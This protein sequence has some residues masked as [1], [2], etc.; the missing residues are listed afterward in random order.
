MV[1][2]LVK[3]STLTQ[4]KSKIGLYLFIAFLALL[5][6]GIF[7][8]YLP[9]LP[10]SSIKFMLLPILAL[11]LIGIWAMPERESFIEDKTR[12]GLY[13]FLGFWMLWPPYLSLIKL[14]GDPWLS[15]QRIAIYILLVYTM[16]MFS[17]SKTA[18]Q[19][20]QDNYRENRKLFTALLLLIL[21]SFLS[22]FISQQIES[23]TTNFIKDLMFNYLVFYLA[24]TLISSG[25]HLRIIFLI[26]I[27]SA[28]ILGSMSFYENTLKQT[29]W[30]YHLPRSFFAY[31]EV[32]VEILSSKLRDGAYR[33]KGSS[34]TSLEYA[35]LLS[36]TLPMCLYY[37]FDNKGKFMKP[38][39]VITIFVI[40]Y[41]II[42]SRSRLGLVGAIVGIFNYIFLISL[43]VW[44]VNKKSLIGPALLTLY[45]AA[46]ITVSVLITSSTTLS[47]MVLGGSGQ[48]SSTNAR[49]DMWTMGLPLIAKQ[50]LIGYGLGRGATV[51]DYR[52]PSG[53][54]TIDSYI[55][56][57]LLDTG[58]MGG[59]AFL[60]FY[61]LGI[62][63]ASR[64]Y[65][66]APEGDDFG[67]T[68]AVLSSILIA[69]L[70][71]KL[72]LSQAYNH[73]LVFL[74]VG[75]VTHYRVQ[76]NSEK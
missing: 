64:S 29:I 69:F 45:P 60:V 57:I 35:E 4:R 10:M 1:K 63:K 52:T 28:L 51:L 58:L 73:T 76:L 38:L 30:S 16:I 9:L 26:C 13:I 24:A 33:N 68:G 54:L 19:T 50:P 25:K 61:V 6:G 53:F 65:I 3:Y 5:F 34:L 56:Q 20:L 49:F 41:A 67:K 12:I 27:F 2:P 75:V 59:L 11:I 39:V 22:I 66:Y 17:I 62:A 7:G 74:L 40:F 32:M 55:L 70:F 31:T 44:R 23:S 37:L 14:S 46:L 8:V 15:P 48:E 18:K 21:A 36:Y 42:V 71:I 43:Q 72:V 47:R